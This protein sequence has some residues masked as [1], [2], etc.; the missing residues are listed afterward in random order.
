MRTKRIAC[1][2]GDSVLEVLA[3]VPPELQP[4]AVFYEDADWDWSKTYIE[5]PLEVSNDLSF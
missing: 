5:Y 2:E 3:K 1:D 4:Y